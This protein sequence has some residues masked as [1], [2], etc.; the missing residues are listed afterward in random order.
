MDPKETLWLAGLREGRV[1][2][3][4]SRGGSMLPFLREGDVVEVVRARQFRIGDIVQVQNMLHRVVAKRNGR[5]ITKGDASSKLDPPVAPE[6]IMGRV[7]A[8]ERRGQVRRLDHLGAR[9]LGLAWCLSSWIPGL[10]SFLASA[11]R[12]LRSVAGVS[13][14]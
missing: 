5:V 7:V 10:V 9:F 4:T 8:L 1:M 11:R 12:A 6:E 2:R 3:C 14:L 13:T